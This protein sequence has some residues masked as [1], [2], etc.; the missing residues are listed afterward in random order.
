MRVGHSTVLDVQSA[1]SRALSTKQRVEPLHV[2]KFPPC[3]SDMVA[4]IC[5]SVEVRQGWKA[6]V[7]L[8]KLTLL[9]GPWMHNSYLKHVTATEA[10][11]RASGTAYR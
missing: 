11:V 8:A 6:N 10:L 9:L 7:S 2:G 5:G 1:K 4:N 3:A